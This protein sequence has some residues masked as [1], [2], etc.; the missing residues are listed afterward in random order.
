MIFSGTLGF[1][2]FPIYIHTQGQP[3]YFIHD[4]H[5]WLLFSYV[6]SLFSFCSVALILKFQRFWFC[7]F[8]ERGLCVS[9]LCYNQCTLPK[10]FPAIL[11]WESGQLCFHLLL[12]SQ[13]SFSLHLYLLNPFPSLWFYLFFYEKKIVL[14]K[15]T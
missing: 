8:E 10:E 12:K 11:S 4:W 13:Q 14:I 1:D 7:I 3:S 6:C 15:L 5:M 9:V 2:C